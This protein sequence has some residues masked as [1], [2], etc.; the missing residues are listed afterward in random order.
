MEYESLVKIWNWRDDD[1]K[2]DET[3]KKSKFYYDVK[4]LLINHCEKE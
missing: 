3:F 2:I 4:E 1:L